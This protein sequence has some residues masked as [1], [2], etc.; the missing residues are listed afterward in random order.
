MSR[1]LPIPWWKSENLKRHFDKHPKGKDLECWED[2]L[3]HPL[4]GVTEDRYRMASLDVIENRWLNY[5][6]EELDIQNY[7][8]KFCS[9]KPF[10]PRRS[11]FVD[12][13]TL[14]TVVNIETQQIHSCFHEH[15]GLKHQANNAT[16]ANSQIR[17][18][19]SLKDDK[20][21]KM[22]KHLTIKEFRSHDIPRNLINALED[23]IKAIV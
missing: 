14:I 17:F 21:S 4:G 6:A 11:Y 16:L 19:E 7:R 2:L 1:P 3:N 5:E 9:E 23:Y 13:K 20:L 8:P 10:H 12:K 15:Y 18:I 22:V